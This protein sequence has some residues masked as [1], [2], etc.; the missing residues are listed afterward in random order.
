[1]ANE[2]QCSPENSRSS[3]EAGSRKEET[4]EEE[5]WKEEAESGRKIQRKFK[6]Q[7]NRGENH[8]T[9]KNSKASRGKSAA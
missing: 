4:R 7:K 8:G 5:S 2:Q 3:E 9:Q 1:M 6:G